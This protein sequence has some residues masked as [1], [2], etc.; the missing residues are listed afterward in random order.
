MAKTSGHSNYKL[1]TSKQGILLATSSIILRPPSILTASALKKFSFQ[2]VPV[3]R[4]PTQHRKDIQVL[5][6]VAVLSVVLF[7]ARESLFL[8]GIWESM[9]FL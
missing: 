4:I 9:Y 7:H 5:R 6:G 8:W 3:T 1:L 2:G